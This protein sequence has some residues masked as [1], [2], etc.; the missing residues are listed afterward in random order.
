MG[1]FHL[2]QAPKTLDS[3][4]PIMQQIETIPAWEKHLHLTNS[5]N[6][7]KMCHHIYT[8]FCCWIFL[9]GKVNLS[10]K[11]SAVHRSVN[12]CFKRPHSPFSCVSDGS[13]PWRRLLFYSTC[14]VKIEQWSITTLTAASE[15][16]LS[17]GNPH[18][19]PIVEYHVTI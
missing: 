6:L 1:T 5:N 9:S 4:F 15:D 10:C 14:S 3:L 17:G 7:L 13:M 12:Y 18:I 2:C 11:I 16:G 19:W 8:V